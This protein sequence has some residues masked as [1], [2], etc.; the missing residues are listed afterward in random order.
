MA[1]HV[2]NLAQDGERDEITLSDS[3]NQLFDHENEAGPPELA[4]IVWR[5]GSP[6]DYQG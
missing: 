6:V 3:A 1:K 2:L 4:P 5:A